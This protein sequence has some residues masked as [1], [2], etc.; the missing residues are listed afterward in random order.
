MPTVHRTLKHSWHM[1]MSC[2]FQLNTKAHRTCWL[3][4]SKLYV[5]DDLTVRSLQ[6]WD[7]VITKATTHFHPV[8]IAGEW[9]SKNCSVMHNTAVCLDA[10]GTSC[11][12]WGVLLTGTF[13][14]G[15]ASKL[16][17]LCNLIMPTGYVIHQQVWHSRTVRSAHTVFMFFFGIYLRTN[18]Y[19]CHLQHKLISFYNRDEKCLRVYSALRTGSL[20]KA[21]CAPSLN[22]YTSLAYPWNVLTLVSLT[23]PII[24]N[25]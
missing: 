16:R 20:N 22:G 10:N 17:C 8:H 11:S 24:I 12:N 25:R 23:M 13:R 21:V 3:F 15:F 6:E 5:L 4:S 2:V 1:S 14:L 18:N 9:E 19:L 7:W